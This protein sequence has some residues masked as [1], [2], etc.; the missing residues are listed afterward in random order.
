MNL[1]ILSTEEFLR[2]A[3]NQIDDLT[4]S[5]IERELLRR[6]E[7]RETDAVAALDETEFSAE[8]ILV[9]G[10]AMSHSEVESATA[11]AKLLNAVSDSNFTVDALIEIIQLL[12]ETG[13]SEA[14]ELSAVLGLTK[15]FR[16]LAND[17]G[18]IFSRLHSLTEQIQ[19]D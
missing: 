19:E 14:D 10:E 4:S 1:N 3:H 9:L 13:I 5:D 8:E 15:D 16:T 11:V 17:A 7:A 18:D 2:Y 6:L 12:Q